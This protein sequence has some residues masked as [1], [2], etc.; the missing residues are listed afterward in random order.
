MSTQILPKP[1]WPT[2]RQVVIYSPAYGP[3]SCVLTSQKFPGNKGKSRERFFLF[4]FFFFNSSTCSLS[5]DLWNALGK[6]AI[7]GSRYKAHCN[8]LE[9]SCVEVSR[10]RD[11]SVARPATYQSPG[12]DAGDS[13][14]SNTESQQWPRSLCHFLHYSHPTLACST[15]QSPGD[16][17]SDSGQSNTESHCIAIVFYFFLKHWPERDKF[18]TEHI[19]VLPINTPSKFAFENLPSAT[20]V[21]D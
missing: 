21:N 2:L 19:G 6:I 11:C 7:R 16:D 17:A 5:S 15:Y 20:S 8:I 1:S 12:D 3:L 13:G 18:I 10:S 9:W 14:Q 4:F